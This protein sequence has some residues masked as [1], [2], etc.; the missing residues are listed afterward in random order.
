MAPQGTKSWTMLGRHALVAPRITSGVGGFSVGVLRKSSGFCS[1]QKD[2][3][4]ENLR[5]RR[6]FGIYRAEVLRFEH[7]SESP[8]S[9]V[10]T[11]G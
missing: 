3:V 6:D 4:P 11:D 5:T 2:Q 10:I 1:N 9:F 7:A 8:R